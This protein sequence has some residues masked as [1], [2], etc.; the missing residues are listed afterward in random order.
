M[1]S[2]QR[3]S[4]AWSPWRSVR[5]WPQSLWGQ[6]LL[7]QSVSVLLIAGLVAGATHSV[8]A[9]ELRSLGL[10]L[11]RLWFWCFP[12]V[13]VVSVWAK[14]ANMPIWWRWIHA[15]FPPLVLLMQQVALPPS[16]YL[17]G[18]IIS[19]TLY[20]S[21]HATRVPFYPSFPATWRALHRILEKHADDT[22]LRVLDI[23]SGLGDISL[24]L[25]KQ[26]VH[27][28]VMGIEIAPLPWAVSAV[29]SIFSGTS[30]HFVLGDY[31]QLDFGQQDVVFAYLS[32]AVMQAVWQKVCQEMQPGSLFISSEFPVP[33]KAA[34]HIVFPAPGAPALYVYHR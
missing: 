11:D 15:V 33:D 8:F 2:M 20:W 31:R 32:P 12:H 29:R 4:A 18:F 14:L 13:I 16:V 27:D 17:A 7:I 19:V 9:F 26:R 28:S 10:P 30:A 22:P 25:A 3:V 24:F 21:V 5:G 6:A 23:G 34:D 1:H